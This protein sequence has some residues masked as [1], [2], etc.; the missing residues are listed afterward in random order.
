MKLKKWVALAAALV[1]TL[2]A[3]SS[4]SVGPVA[5]KNGVAIESTKELGLLLLDEAGVKDLYTGS[6]VDTDELELAVQERPASGVDGVVV[7]YG[8]PSSEMITLLDNY[9]GF[10]ELKD[11]VTTESNDTLIATLTGEYQYTQ[12]QAEATVAYL[13]PDAT[14][15]EKDYALSVL[16]AEAYIE[17]FDTTMEYAEQSREKITI[18]G[19]PSELLD[20]TYVDTNGKLRDLWAVV[21]AGD[22]MYEINAW[23][24]EEDFTPVVD[25]FKTA[26]QSITFPAPAGE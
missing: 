8:Y 7:V 19:H 3:C 12:A 16:Y 6:D 13:K 18:D 9:Y 14:E 11:I 17:G 2:T 4:A 22:K 26:V 21:F 24:A 15:A 1:L 25:A 20:Y 23:G 10:T 5:G